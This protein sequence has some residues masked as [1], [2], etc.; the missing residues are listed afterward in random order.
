ML[1][2]I[3]KW[4]IWVV[5]GAAVAA[6]AIVYF[7]PACLIYSTFGIPCPT[8]GMTR[9]WLAALH[10]DFKT[11]FSMHPMFWSIPIL[12]IYALRDCR[13]VRSKVCNRLILGAILF[14]FAVNYIVILMEWFHLI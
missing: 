2:R 1:A 10:L 13:L 11:A 9:A 7:T 5:V 3:P 4:K 12:G 14:G 8:C 6:A